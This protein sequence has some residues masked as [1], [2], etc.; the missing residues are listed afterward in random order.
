MQSSLYFFSALV[1]RCRSLV[2]RRLS[3]S[4][5]IL[6]AQH[7]APSV[8]NIAA[9]FNS[10]IR[11]ADSLFAI[12]CDVFACPRDYTV[13]PAI[14]EDSGLRWVKVDHWFSRTVA[15]S[16]LLRIPLLT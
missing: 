4:R 3:R 5:L 2:M 8:E 6:S 7:V 15:D 10:A 11:A 13:G 14:M 12:S 16:A 1:Q 9:P